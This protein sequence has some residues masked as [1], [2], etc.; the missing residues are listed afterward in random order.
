MNI[1]LRWNGPWR[2]NSERLL[3]LPPHS[4]SHSCAPFC[5]YSKFKFRRTYVTPCI[6]WACLYALLP[7][8]T[9]RIFCINLLQNLWRTLT[10][11]FFTPRCLHVTR[12]H[13]HAEV[14]V[15]ISILL[16]GTTTC[17]VTAL[18]LLDSHLRYSSP[19]FKVRLFH[20]AQ[21]PF[22]GTL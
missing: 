4:A 13:A 16:R 11:V 6:S 21:Y 5:F 10:R 1:P 12:R 19:F 18:P 8:H 20:W 15:V 17:K 7:M 2:L 9:L 22:V 14:V 3:V